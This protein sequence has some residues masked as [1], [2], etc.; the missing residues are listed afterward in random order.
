M[1]NVIYLTDMTDLIRRIIRE[2]TESK[3]DAI[4]SMIKKSGLETAA[5]VMGGINNIIDIVYDGDLI[6]FSEDT[7]TPIAYMSS[8][9]LNLYL[10]EA[11]V[12]QLGI[13][14]TTNPNDQYYLGNFTFGS[15]NGIQ[16]SIHIR[17][18]P[19]RLHNQLYYKVVGS[20]GDYGFGHHFISK[21]NTL[22]K[23]YRQQIYKQIIDK[24]DLKPYMKI[25]TFY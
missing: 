13:Q 14:D 1:N 19:L 25:K 16:Y 22:G 21:K 9:E 18:E 5:R 6:K 23:R 10:H 15:K 8:I 20:S 4:K 3:K 7:I 24:Y 11:L 2:E 12:K 17:L